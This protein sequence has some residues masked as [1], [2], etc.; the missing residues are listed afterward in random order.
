M[1]HFKKIAD[2]YGY[3]VALAAVEALDEVEA[4]GGMN[5]GD[6]LAL[7]GAKLEDAEE[8]VDPADLYVDLLEDDEFVSGGDGLLLPYDA[9]AF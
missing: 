8:E 5:A 6:F 7:L 9:E 1:K 4:A 3:N 2:G